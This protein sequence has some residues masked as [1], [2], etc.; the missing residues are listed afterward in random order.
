MI[1][2]L[3]I[4][5]L[6]LLVIGQPRGSQVSIE[7]ASSP[8]SWSH[9]APR[10]DDPELIRR[11]E[12]ID[13]HAAEVADLTA[14]FEQRRHTPLLK[15]PLVSSGRVRVMGAII[16]W[17]TLAPTASVLMMDAAS[18]RIFYP[19]QGA[20]EIYPIAS[21]LARL[22]ATPLPRLEIIREQFSIEECKAS[23]FDRVPDEP[24]SPT[25]AIR[26]LP[27]TGE[28]SKTIRE[29]RVL[30]DEVPGVEAAPGATSADKRP[31]GVA[32]QVE[33]TD[34]D[35]DRTVMV[36]ERTRLNSG[37]KGADLELTVPPGTKVSRPL[38]MKS[39]DVRSDGID[40]K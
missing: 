2:L 6:V 7:P 37:L 15:K 25:V 40:R 14:D 3:A 18:L 27:K 23:D 34:A 5:G 24:T 32:R 1:T 35:G 33:V 39:S 19:D 4:F 38:E 12:S 10:Q 31:Y 30:L 17:D 26:L 9:A 16:R 22:A 8:A 21:G 20:L 11:L 29:V 13:R 28:L 36:F